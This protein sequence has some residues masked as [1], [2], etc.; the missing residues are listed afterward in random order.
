[1]LF[2]IYA[3]IFAAFFGI[4]DRWS[5][6]GLWWAKLGRDNGGPL[7][8][9]PRNYVLL[10]V[11]GVYL[12]ITLA[13]M[14]P[15]ALAAFAAGAS[16]KAVA[17]SFGAMFVGTVKAW[18]AFA[19]AGVSFV[20]WRAVGWDFIFG[21]TMTPITREDTIRT[22]LRH[23]LVC[24]PLGGAVFLGLASWPV[25]AAGVA[26]A[27]VATYLGVELAKGYSRGE[28]NNDTVELNR[29]VAYGLLIG[30][31]LGLPIG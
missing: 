9:H 14:F 4:A 7:R 19:V 18:P 12:A 28:D 5:G 13:I 24:L 31:A 2:L 22:F 21:G 23:S 17:A 26:F 16:F 6:G 1:M 8:S 20:L 11:L 29:G 15:V 10:I 30:S 27:A 3:V 25:I